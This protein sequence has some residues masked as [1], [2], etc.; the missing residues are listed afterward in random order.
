MELGSFCGG[1]MIG[2]LYGAIIVYVNW[3]MAETRKKMAAADNPFNKFPDAV[4]PNLTAA[5][6]TR[7]SRN[8]RFTYA[9]LVVFLAVFILSYPIV[10]YLLL[11]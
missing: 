2:A 11:A 6:V 10:I 8:A 7:T 9:A 3:Q 4:Q 1:S 5:G